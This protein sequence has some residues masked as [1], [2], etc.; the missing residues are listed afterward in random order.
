MERARGLTQASIIMST[1]LRSKSNDQECSRQTSRT[2]AGGSNQRRQRS[3]V[4]GVLACLLLIGPAKAG[5]AGRR[6]I[7]AGF[8][9]RAPATS[10]ARDSPAEQGSAHSLRRLEGWNRG[11]YPR[12]KGV[13]SM[14][15]TTGAAGLQAETPAQQS[16]CEE[17]THRISGVQLLSSCCQT[18]LAFFV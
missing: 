5:P 10:A 11:R 8:V 18:G 16:R 7:M 3:R 14:A 12:R 2:F 17:K 6:G 9:G 1:V 13:A 15:V 4:C